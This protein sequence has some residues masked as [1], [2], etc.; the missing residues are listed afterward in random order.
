MSVQISVPSGIPSLVTVAT[1]VVT[2][3]LTS[4]SS[5]T[6]VSSTS[7]L[8]QGTL[9]CTILNSTDDDSIFSLVAQIYL[10]VFSGQL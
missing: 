8:G 4:P 1:A 7:T 3:R 10:S 5:N 6:C 2:L 9:I